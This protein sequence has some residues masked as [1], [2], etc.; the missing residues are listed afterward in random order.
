MESTRERWHILFSGKVQHVGFRYTAYYIARDLGLTG[1]VDNLP[2][3]RVEMEVQGRPSDLRRLLL[4]LKGQ[5]HIRII[6][7]QIRRI[8]RRTLE[9]RFAVRGGGD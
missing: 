9:R 1:W 4:R 7:T 8:P 2:D 3:G 5:R 6:Q